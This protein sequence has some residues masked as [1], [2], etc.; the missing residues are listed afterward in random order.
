MLYHL[1]ISCYDI[2]IAGL[3]KQKSVNL[4]FFFPNKY[5]EM[6]LKLL[7]LVYSYLHSLTLPI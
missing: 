5:I 4:E 1:K 6:A 7:L 3:V 2:S